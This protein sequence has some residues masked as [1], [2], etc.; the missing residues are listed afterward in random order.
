MARSLPLPSRSPARAP[1]STERRALRRPIAPPAGAQPIVKWVGGKGKLIGDLAARAPASY[2]RY[3]EP[4]VGGGALFFHLAPRSAV[5]SDVNADLV[6]CYR[7]VRDDVEAVIAALA[8]HRERHSIEYYYAVRDGWNDGTERGAAGRAATFIYLNKTCYN[9]LWRVNARGGFN[10]PMGRYVNP[11]ILDAERLRA[12]SAALG[13]AELEVRSFE[14]VLEEAKRGD[15]VYFDPPYHPLSATADFTTYAA[16]GFG[17]EDQERLAGVFAR[18][19]ERGCA[20]MLSNSD[21]P[22]TRRLYARYRVDRVYAPRAVNS[23]ADRRGAV[24]EILVSNRY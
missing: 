20:V 5:L 13:N 9:G 15:L 24:A 12:A 10:V 16:G 2:R 17:A 7:A 14:G 8:E 22:F 18:L 6:A 4:F 3:F 11:S 23:R 19:A 1:L 21:T